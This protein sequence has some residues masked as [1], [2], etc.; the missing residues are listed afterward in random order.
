MKKWKNRVL[1]VTAAFLTVVMTVVSVSAASVDLNGVYPISTNEIAGWPVGPEISSDTGVLIEAST[2]TVVYNKGADELRYPASITKLMTLLVAVE[3]CDLD[4]TVTFTETGIRDIAPDSANIG[5]QLGETMSMKDCLY[6]LIIRSANE[7]ASQI[8]EYVGGTEQGFIDM[9]N[10]RAEKIGCTNTHF[11]NASGLP[12]EAHYT[13]A[14][15]MAMIFRECLRNKTCRKILKTPTYYIEPTNMNGER[16]KLHTHHPLFA[17]ESALYYEGCIGGKTGMTNDAGHT[18]VT[19]VKKDG[20]TYIAVVMRAVDLNQACL[21]SRLLFD[22]GFANFQKTEFKNGTVVIPMETDVNT[23]TSQEEN[24][25]GKNMEGYYLSGYRVGTGSV[26]VP[27]PTVE[28]VEEAADGDAEPLYTETES[29]EKK[30][31]ETDRS[32]KEKGFSDLSK[33]LLAVMGVMVVILIVL[34]IALA[35]KNKKHENKHK[36]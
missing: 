29:S 27:T 19:G 12:D 15:D 5:M 3:N 9:M 31:E 36:R 22:Y 7:V 21:D 20:V 11:T 28:V 17:K 2:G 23:L 16:R 26:T 6:A 18:L 25:N 4:E 35:I 34:L 1:A 13:T 33:I 8:A 24:L 32:V 30:T 10:A 14:K